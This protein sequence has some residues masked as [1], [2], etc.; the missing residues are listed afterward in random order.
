L[1][2]AF[3]ENFILPLSHDEVVH[4]K[5]SLLGRM[6]GDEWQRFANLR[7][8]YGFMFGHPGKKLLFM[9]SEFGQESEW[10]HDHSLDWHLLKNPRH[11]GVQALVRD[12]NRLYRTIPALHELDCDDAGFEWLV[13][14]DAERGVFAWVRKGR[15]TRERCLVVVNFTPEVYRDYRIKVPFAGTWREILNSDSARYGGSN[16]G[17]YGSAVAFANGEHAELG[18]T[19][20]PLATLFLVPEL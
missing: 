11:E 7:A 13:M 2:Y 14:H 15:Q 17:N 12:L 8:Y 20:P 18:L 5:R 4:G 3:F 19:L 1:H 10:R 16:V 9:G 6:P